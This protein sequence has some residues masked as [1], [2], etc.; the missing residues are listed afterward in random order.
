M[1][2][3]RFLLIKYFF[4]CDTQCEITLHSIFNDHQEAEGSD[5]RIDWEETRKVHSGLTCFSQGIPRIDIQ[6]IPGI[7]Q[8]EIVYVVAFVII[9]ILQYWGT[10]DLFVQQILL[11]IMFQKLNTSSVDHVYTCVNQTMHMVTMDMEVAQMA[12]RLLQ[13]TLKVP[14]MVAFQ[15]LAMKNCHVC[16]KPVHA[17]LF[18]I[19]KFSSIP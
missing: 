6:D 7:S 11:K 15:V 12:L 5:K 1:L 16:D 13:V 4:H 8:S 9:C 10:D 19:K 17:Q 18:T 3:N 14:Y 2:D